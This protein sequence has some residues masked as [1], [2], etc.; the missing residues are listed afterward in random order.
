M[1]SITT[2]TKFK[3]EFYDVDSMKI[4]WHGN[5][6]KYFEKAR[7]TLLD[8]IGY[9]YSDM[10]KSD[11]AFPVTDV[12]VKYIRPL[13]F[14]DTVRIN[15]TLIEYENRI[16]IKYEIYNDKTGILST[17]GESTQMAVKIAT[18]ETC[19]VCPDELIKKVEFLLDQIE[20]DQKSG[21]KNSI[22]GDSE[23]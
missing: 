3:I 9:T 6:I 10:L 7:C 22:K 1:N 15:A 19:F 18:R 2:T 14:G 20:S 5:Y 16:K 11:Y 23:L 21:Q 17:K 12:R 4:V 8:K 13:M